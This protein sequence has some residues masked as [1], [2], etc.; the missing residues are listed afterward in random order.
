MTKS[1]QIIRWRIF[2]IRKKAE[3]QYVG[4]VQATDAKAAIRT[5]IHV[6]D[7]TDPELQKRL[8]AQ[9]EA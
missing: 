5:A 7:I 2:V 8:R 1:K 4:T 6:F 9:R 3:A